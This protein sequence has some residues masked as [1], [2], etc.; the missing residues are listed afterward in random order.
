MG[1]DNIK[2]TMIIT[3][4]DNMSLQN[5]FKKISWVK[6]EYFKYKFD[7]YFP[8]IKKRT[9]DEFLDHV[10]RKS[11][12]PFE[13]WE[14]TN[15]YKELVATYLQSKTANDLLQI[16]DAVVDK[17]KQGDDRAITT[18]LKLQKEIDSIV[19]DAD[20]NNYDDVLIV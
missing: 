3:G 17:A 12:I 13:K 19:K 16:Y 2:L 9:P 5:R 6:R 4:V 15:E 10:A 1:N 8:E 7:D 11:F 20:N 18:L 14:R